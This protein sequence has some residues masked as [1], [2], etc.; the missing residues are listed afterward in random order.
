MNTL[1]AMLFLGLALA[2][3]ATWLPIAV[4]WNND[5]AVLPYEPRRQVPWGFVGAIPAILLVTLTLIHVMSGAG[6]PTEPDL[7]ATSVGFAVLTSVFAAIVITLSGATASDLGLP[8]NRIQLQGDVRLGAAGWLACLLPVFGVQYV[9]IILFG[10]T[11]QNPVIKLVEERP[12]WPILA[13]AF[14]SAVIVAP[15]CEE[16]IFR[17]LLQGWLERVEGNLRVRTDAPELVTPDAGENHGDEESRAELTHD[18]NIERSRG[19]KPILVSSLL[20]SLAHFGNGPDPVAI[21]V[22]ALFLGYLYQ[23]THRLVPCVVVHMLFNGL[24][25]VMLWLS[26]AAEPQ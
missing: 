21:F 26:L 4:R 3:L 6:P 22:F 7:V 12:E 16:L 10:Q 19:V 1:I 23:R 14:F 18:E 20:F 11:S 15:I 8:L 9:L 5:G 17:V 2:S 25:L 13:V 24:S